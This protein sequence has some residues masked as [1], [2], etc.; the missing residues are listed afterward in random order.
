MGCLLLALLT[1]N[2]RHSQLKYLAEAGTNQPFDATAWSN[3]N[4]AAYTPADFQSEQNALPRATVEWTFG[5]RSSTGK[6]S[7]LHF[8]TNRLMR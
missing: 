6:G 5:T 1:L 8:E 2:P 4:I 7:V 3:R